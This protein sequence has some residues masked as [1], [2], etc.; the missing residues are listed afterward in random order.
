MATRYTTCARTYRRTQRDES[1]IERA[2]DRVIVVEQL[3]KR[4][5]HV[6][7]IHVG[8]GHYTLL[9]KKSSGF[10]CAFLEKIEAIREILLLYLADDVIHIGNWQPASYMNQ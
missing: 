5:T 7:N 9:Y 3:L 6:E 10:S 8:R 1:E 2:K 4:N